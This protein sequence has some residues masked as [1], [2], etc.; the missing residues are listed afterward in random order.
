MIGGTG[1]VNYLATPRANT[2]VGGAVNAF[3]NGGMSVSGERSQT[4]M[5]GPELNIRASNDYGHGSIGLSA[6]Y[7]VAQ[8]KWAAYARLGFAPIS[9]SY[10]NSV[11]Y[12]SLNTGL[13]L[14]AGI[15]VG[16]GWMT[17]T[18]VVMDSTMLLLSLRSDVDYRP[19]QS[20]ADLFL[21]FNIGV[22]RYFGAGMRSD[23]RTTLSLRPA[24][25]RRGI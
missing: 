9:G 12:Y 13:E 20:Q 15:T 23:T 16:T 25:E 21:S 2:P 3:I 5:F 22:M 1:G 18:G 4:L 11:L 14:G 19:G 10:R 6:A 24:T 7:V 8:P 17:A